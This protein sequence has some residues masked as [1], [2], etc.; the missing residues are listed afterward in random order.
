[1]YRY[2][3]LNL[4]LIIIIIITFVHKEHLHIYFELFNS[5]FK[6]NFDL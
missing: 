4:D 5:S 6:Y 2:T 3:K 1:M